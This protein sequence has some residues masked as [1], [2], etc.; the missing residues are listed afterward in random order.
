MLESVSYIYYTNSIYN[1]LTKGADEVL[2]QLP[3][4]SKGAGNMVT[5]S[6]L[7]TFVIMLCA[8]ITLVIHITRKK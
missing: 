1:I 8:V 6:D 7:F 5:Y 4:I 2:C 3:D